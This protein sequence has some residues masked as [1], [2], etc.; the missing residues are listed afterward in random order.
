MK[1]IIVIFSILLISIYA[2]A[3]QMPLPDPNTPNVLFLRFSQ[4]LNGEHSFNILTRIRSLDG[5][6]YEMQNGYLFYS[7]DNR[8]RSMDFEFYTPDKNYFGYTEIT[9][10]N[11]VA[12][13]NNQL[14]DILNSKEDY[15]R[16]DYLKSFSKIYIIDLDVQNPRQPNKYKIIEVK[17][18]FEDDRE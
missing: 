8:G 1:K 10:Y 6:N 9:P 16:L 7:N 3:Q 18:Y 11:S 17:V 13:T 2:K 12:I 14:K 5:V 15:L 4:A